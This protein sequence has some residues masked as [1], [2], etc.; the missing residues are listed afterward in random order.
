[1]P[2]TDLP[3]IARRLKT[4]IWRKRLTQA[5]VAR[6]AGMTEANLSEILCGGRP[7]PQIGTVERIVAATGGTMA[8]L[9]QD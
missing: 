7:N 1:M 9:Y 2:R 3:L 5:A 8:E 6:A 4:L